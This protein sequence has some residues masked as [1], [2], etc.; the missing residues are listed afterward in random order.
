MFLELTPAVERALGTARRL[1]RSAGLDWVGPAQLLYGLLEEEEGRAWSML[2]EGGV[3][4]A[5]I[6]RLLAPAP[7][8]DLPP[9]V[10]SLPFDPKLEEVLH[11]ARRIAVGSSADR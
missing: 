6:R 11:A 4:A 5:C 10:G 8:A 2:G 1:T 9:D 3:D 7:A